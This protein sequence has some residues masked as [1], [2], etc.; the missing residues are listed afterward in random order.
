MTA[1]LQARVS[2][3]GSASV[4]DHISTYGPGNWIVDRDDDASDREHA[5]PSCMNASSTGLNVVTHLHT[6]QFSQ[7][8]AG[9]LF[10]VQLSSLFDLPP[11]PPTLLLSSVPRYTEKPV[12]ILVMCDLSSIFSL[13]IVK[14]P[15]CPSRF[16]CVS[17][18]VYSPAWIGLDPVRYS[19]WSVY[20]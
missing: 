9:T 11:N 7:V 1:L 18:F 5:N 13:H 19:G 16:V 14:Y 4:G 17:S 2:R 6:G 20:G 12:S 8:Q 15:V 10:I 3:G